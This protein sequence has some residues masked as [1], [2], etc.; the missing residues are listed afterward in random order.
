MST[1]ERH[2]DSS[3]DISINLLPLKWPRET[4]NSMVR[5]FKIPD[6]WDARYPD[7][8]QTAVD[9]PARYNTLVSYFFSA[10]NFRLPVTMFF[11][12]RITNFTSLKCTLLGWFEFMHCSQG[13]YSFVQRASAKKILWRPPKSFH[14]WKPKFFFM[15][16]GM[17]PMKMTFR[18]KKDVATE[19]IQTPFSEAW[20][21]DLKD[22]PSIMLPEKALVGAGRSLFWRM[23]REDKPVYME[24]DKV[25]S[26]YVIA[27][28]REG[29]SMATIP[30]RADEELWYLQIVK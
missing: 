23:E 6:S 11:L 28:E 1:G 14:D 16:T 25:V 8:G 15:K 17:I 3:L 18:G 7:E 29:G 2:E 12:E 26:L 5:N 9:A 10:G 30:K 24:D 27:F 20:Y 13:F 22:I 4:F 19:T 21:Q